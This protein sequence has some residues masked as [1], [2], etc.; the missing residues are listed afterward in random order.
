MS[1]SARA[2]LQEL[3]RRRDRAA[4]AHDRLDQERGDVVAIGL[5]H[6]LEPVGVVHR[7]RVDQGAQHVRDAGA[8]G[9][10]LRVAVA[11]LPVLD[12]R[13]PERGVEHPVIAALDDD[14]GILAG[15]G[16]RDAQCRH[17]RLGAGIGEAHELGRRH[18]AGDP[19][20]HRALTLGG[21]G[22]DA[23]DLDAGAG[24]G[25]HPRVGVA[26]DAGAVGQAVVD[27]FVA[28]DVGQARALGR[29][30]V[31]GL[32]LAPVAEIRRNPEGEAADGLLELGVG[33]REASS[34]DR[35]P[36]AGSGTG[37][38]GSPSVPQTGPRRPF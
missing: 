6:G 11:R 27:V 37:R 15:V 28:V 20:G 32:V 38:S 19:L 29:L 22:E 21:E 16:A 36:P 9:H 33:L 25:I 10:E 4:V 35:R 14:V 26:E 30:H 7:H 5:E 24:R 13:V 23:A 17:H 12:G 31:D 2:S 18:H 34:H 1:Q 3:A 8:V